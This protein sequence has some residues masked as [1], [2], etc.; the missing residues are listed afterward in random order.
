[1]RSGRDSFAVFVAD[2]VAADERDRI[3]ADLASPASR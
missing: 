1:V 2:T 3:Y